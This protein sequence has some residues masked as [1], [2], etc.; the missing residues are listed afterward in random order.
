MRKACLW[1]GFLFPLLSYAGSTYP[2]SLLPEYLAHHLT[3]K[4]Q[5][6]EPTCWAYA[7]VGALEL[8]AS[9]AEGPAATVRFDE[10]TLLQWDQQARAHPL[11]EDEVA[12]RG[13]RIESRS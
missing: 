9:R 5:G 11:P 8:V 13:P 7:F 12:F 4:D 2:D 3:V 10:R 1:V 6:D